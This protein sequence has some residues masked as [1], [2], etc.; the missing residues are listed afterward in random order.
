MPRRN[1][2]VRDSVW[3]MHVCCWCWKVDA[4]VWFDV[5]YGHPSCA[6]GNP[7]SV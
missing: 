7:Y 5:T 3:Y 4:S 2:S 1:E 6:S